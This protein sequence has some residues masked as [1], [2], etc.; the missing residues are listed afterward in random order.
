MT[1]EQ[2]HNNLETMIKQ[3]PGGIP[4][5]Q[6]DQMKALK[7]EL[8]RRGAAQRE[9]QPE[10]PKQIEVSEMS[11]EQLGNELQR[12][13]QAISKSPHDESLQER[14]AD[15]RFALRAQSKAPAAS[16]TTPRKIRK[17]QLDFTP[18]A[19]NEIYPGSLLGEAMNA[20]EKLGPSFTG[21]QL[22]E[23]MQQGEP[24]RKMRPG[25]ARDFE[26]MMR[27]VNIATI[28]SNIAAR[29]LSM[30]DGDINGDVIDETCTV[31]VAAAESIF[32]KLGL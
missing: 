2:I 15:V 21:E 1:T 28:A 26:A 5:Q 11:A 23:A 14:F 18:E 16:M 12:L 24:L 29:I 8:K 31:A 30:G 22:G 9:L 10:E 17:E 27:K 25:G 4:E 7:S 13:S 6:V 32:A 3:W 19:P 20:A